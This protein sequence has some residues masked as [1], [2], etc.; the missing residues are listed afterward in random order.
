VPIDTSDIYRVPPNVGAAL[1]T[2]A[3]AV[4]VRV[5]LAPIFTHHVRGNVA[6]G[7]IGRLTQAFAAFRGDP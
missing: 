2:E 4:E 3:G 1:C 7:A 5:Y 6:A